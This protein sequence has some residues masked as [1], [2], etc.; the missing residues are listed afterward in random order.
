MEQLPTNLSQSARFV[1]EMAQEISPRNGNTQPEH[2]LYALLQIP[3]SEAMK[4]LTAAGVNTSALLDALKSQ[5]R[6][7]AS[8]GA[9]AQST[10]QST[11]DTQAV[12]T[13]ASALAEQERSQ[14]ISP[15]HLLLGL[16][17]GNHFAN[18]LLGQHGA[19]AAQ[20]SET[21]T[22]IAPDAARKKAQ[23][24]G[25][26]NIG[27]AVNISVTFWLLLAAFGVAGW[28]AYSPLIPNRPFAVFLFVMLG[29]IVSLC[30]HEF[31]H[32][33]TAYLLGDESVVEKGYL[34][35]NPLR[36]TDPVFSIIIPVVFLIAGGLGLPGG[37][38][39]INLN[40]LR[41]RYHHSLVAVAG[42]IASALCALL[43]WIPLF[44]VSEES[45]N[46]HYE[47][48]SGWSFL[49]FIQITAVLFNLIP[50]P[51]LDG[52]NILEPFFPES[53]QRMLYPLRQFSFIILM[54]L[55]W[56][57]N[58]VRQGFWQ[59]AFNVMF[60]LQIRFELVGQG[61]ELFRFWT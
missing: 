35:M 47:F 4:M 42:P 9:E 40:N 30:L 11:G 52:Y 46:A 51:P 56:N 27:E 31:G 29:W 23:N 18:Q 44:F 19:N 39:Y 32:A 50:L 60:A 1:V 48:W 25:K 28:L 53:L 13:A 6:I 5:L 24:I 12:I 38:V 15:R 49:L 21:A 57:D 55:F 33:F 34:T 61:S 3:S 10:A 16:F 17:S 43:L 59:L 14:E 41:S 20:L 26:V 22:A 2:L 37:A 45:I 7:L 54:L 58:P 36:Y 8:N